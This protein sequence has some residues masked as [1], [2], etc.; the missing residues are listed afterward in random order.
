VGGVVRARSLAKKLDDRPLAIVD[1]RREH[2]GVSEVM[3]IIGDVK[4]RDCILFD[5]IVDSGGTLVNAA[6]ALMRHG[7]KSVAAYVTHGVLSPG[8]PERIAGGALQRLVVTDSIAARADVV[9]CKKIEFVSCA[10]LLAEAIRRIA[11][12]ESVSSLF[13]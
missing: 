5:D 6:E 13:D 8:A 3:N 1:K 10:D 12:E 2:A 11:N 7:A 4:G 9:A